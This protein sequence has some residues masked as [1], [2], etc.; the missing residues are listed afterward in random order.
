MSQK[1]ICSDCKDEVLK[2]IQ[3][4]IAKQDVEIT[5]LALS[6]SGDDSIMYLARQMVLCGIKSV[7]YRVAEMWIKKE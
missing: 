1:L 5:K 3:E 7:K 6:S 2:V 4:H